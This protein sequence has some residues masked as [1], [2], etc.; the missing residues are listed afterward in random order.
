MLIPREYAGLIRAGLLPVIRRRSR[1][2][3]PAHTLAHLTDGTG[4]AGAVVAQDKLWSD[5]VLVR[6]SQRHNGELKY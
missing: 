6:P 4:E 2:L 1:V 5:T 3:V